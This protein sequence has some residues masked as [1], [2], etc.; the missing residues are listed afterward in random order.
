MTV[1]SRL[2]SLLLPLVLLALTAIQLSACSSS[3]VKESKNNRQ[4]LKNFVVSTERRERKRRKQEENIEPTVRIK[5][6]RLVNIEMLY[7][8][9]LDVAADADVRHKILLRLADLRML[10]S[11]DRQIEANTAEQFYDDAIAF[12]EELIPLNDERVAAKADQPNSARLMYQLAKAYALNGQRDESDAAMAQLIAKFPESKYATEAFFRRGEYAFSNNDYQSAAV[13]YTRVVSDG[14]TSGFY[15]NARYMLGWSRFK[16]NRLDD[17]A[18]SF[19]TLL[20][21]LYV[22]D[23]AVERQSEEESPGQQAQKATKRGAK[24]LVT[25]TVRVLGVIAFY[26]GGVEAIEKRYPIDPAYDPRQAEP[27]PDPAYLAEIYQSLA[28]LYERRELSEQ[29]IATYFA[30]TERNPVH[31]DAVN[32]HLKAIAMLDENGLD[33]RSLN[34]QEVFVTRYGIDGIYKHALND[35]RKETIKPALTKHLENLATAYHA[36]AQQQKVIAQ[37]SAR[38]APS[39]LSAAV[40]ESFIKAADFYN[41]LLRTD[42]ATKQSDILRFRMAEALYDGSLLNQSIENFEALAYGFAKATD[43]TPI[44]KAA[45]DKALGADAGFS[46][47]QIRDE[48]IANIT[49]ASASPEV[50]TSDENAIDDALLE[51]QTQKLFSAEQFVLNYQQD[52]RAPAVLSDALGLVYSQNNFEQSVVLANQLLQLPQANDQQRLDAQTFLANAYFAQ[53]KYEQS[54]QAYRTLLAITP[55]GND[56]RQ[57]VEERLAASMYRIAEQLRKTSGDKNEARA[58]E[59]LML[60]VDKFLSIQSVLPDHPIAITAQFD[61]AEMLYRDYSNK[62]ADKKTTIE[63]S[64]DYSVSRPT[65]VN[66]QRLEVLLLDLQQRYPT[67]KNAEAISPKLV[68]IYEREQRWVDAADLLVALADTSGNPAVAQEASYR[69]AQYFDRAEKT[70][71]AIDQYDRYITRY[72]DP[73]DL[74]AEAL[75]RQTELKEKNPGQYNLKENYRALA[76]LPGNSA[77]LKYLKGYGAIRDARDQYE[78]FASVKLSWP[79]KKSLATK[80]EVMS[81][82]LKSYQAVLDSGVPELVTEANYHIAL[83][84]ATLSEDLINSEPPETLDDLALEQYDII[85]EEQAYPFEEKAIGLFETNARRSADG[86]YDSWVKQS[87]ASLAKLLPVRFGKKEHQLEVSEALQ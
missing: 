39:V 31:P 69:A 22:R 24:N 55:I 36:D 28:A 25:D 84:Y 60:A 62:T 17:S 59:S 18:K 58:S 34:Q 40:K 49:I 7:Q 27:S 38:G 77:R 29:A 6:D 20:D 80:K 65:G 83:I 53:A 16:Q 4:T 50:E 79:I 57:A 67:N 26:E 32:L 41:Q 44:E 70:Q 30:F 8:N 73:L 51:A 21:E 81:R 63:H 37:D 56:R 82:A 12:Y 5:D 35:E 10:K 72:Q 23:E 19:T 66:Y 74:Y 71:A 3:K 85:L 87:F 1:L 2:V 9:A 61:A 47:L 68:T 54:E 64:V 43:A 15:H 45:I 42:P 33:T 76:A 46:A 14:D 78:E 13:N 11:E 86:I 52:S 75:F 48:L